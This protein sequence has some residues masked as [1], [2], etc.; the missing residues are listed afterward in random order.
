ME[1][2]ARGPEVAGVVGDVRE[3]LS[4][5]WAQAEHAVDGL[6]EQARGDARRE[7]VRTVESQV[8][9][10]CF[11]MA[12]VPKM[13]DAALK[14][15]TECIASLEEILTNLNAV[16]DVPMNGGLPVNAPVSRE[17]APAE[18]PPP[19]EFPAPVPVPAQEQAQPQPMPQHGDGQSVESAPPPPPMPQSW[20]VPEPSSNPNQEEYWIGPRTGRPRFRRDSKNESA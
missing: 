9:A 2:M 5:V 13:I 17:P 7:V 15:L 3:H 14:P 4:Q 11:K 1:S 8:G 20:E 19:A 12:Q 10:I 16:S 6:V 18:F